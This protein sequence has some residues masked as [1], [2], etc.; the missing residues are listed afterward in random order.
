MPW[1]ETI[2]TEELNE[3]GT[4]Q[5]VMED[6]H[7]IALIR[8]DNEVYAINDTCSHA[9]ASLA[10]GEIVGDNIKCPLHGAEFDIR[11]GEVQSFPA[12]VGVANYETRIENGK[13]YV[14]YEE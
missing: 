8:I 1:V 14:D 10:E 12:V 6:G 2:A 7:K 5:V 3:S 4:A 13:I 11:T 9:Q